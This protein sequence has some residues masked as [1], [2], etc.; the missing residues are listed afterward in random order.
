MTKIKSRFKKIS[1]NFRF[2]RRNTGREH[3][4]KLKGNRSIVLEQRQAGILL[5][6]FTVFFHCMSLQVS[7]FDFEKKWASDLGYLQRRS[8]L[9]GVN[10]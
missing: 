3:S 9:T 10:M 1:Y 8:L 4:H 7:E 5:R 6:F 2:K